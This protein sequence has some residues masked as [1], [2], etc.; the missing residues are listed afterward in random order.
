MP[1]HV[2]KKRACRLRSVFTATTGLSSRKS[3]CDFL[4]VLDFLGSNER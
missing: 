3:A 2:S 1:L 4:R